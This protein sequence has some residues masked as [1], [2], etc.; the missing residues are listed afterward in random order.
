MSLTLTSLWFV[1]CQTAVV[2][3][4][5]ALNNA[6]L[7]LIRCRSPCSESRMVSSLSAGKIP[8]VKLVAGNAIGLDMERC[9]SLGFYGGVGAGSSF[10]RPI[11]AVG[12]YATISGMGLFFFKK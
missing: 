10:Y 4:M 7:P 5:A 9:R 6:G 1:L 11:K 2:G 3:N 8:F 12:D